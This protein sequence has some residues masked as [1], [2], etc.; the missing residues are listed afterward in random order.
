MKSLARM[1]VLVLIAVVA[2]GCASG[3]AVIA[4]YDRSANFSAY[5]SYA[6]LE[7]VGSDP[8]GYESLATQAVKAAVRREMDA[9]GYAYAAADPDLQVNFSTQLAQKTRISQM[10]GPMFHPWGP[11]GGYGRYGGWGGWGPWGGYGRHGGWGGWG[12]YGGWGYDGW[13]YD[14]YVDQYLEGTLRIDI[15]DARRQQVVWE[16]MAV[17]RVPTRQRQNRQAQAS[18]TVAAIFASYPF[19]AGQ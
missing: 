7:K 17:E 12:G 13:G 10:P 15:V 5:R 14:T 11:Y 18:A 2:A 16:G 3:P 19:R 4:D 1:W 6:F 9:R 8:A